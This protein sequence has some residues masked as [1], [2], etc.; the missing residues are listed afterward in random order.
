M[1]ELEHLAQTISEVSYYID[2][3][4]FTTDEEIRG[5]TICDHLELA[6]LEAI[7]LYQNGTYFVDKACSVPVKERSYTRRRTDVE[8][9][10][11]A[12]DVDLAEATGIPDKAA[13]HIVFMNTSN[14]LRDLRHVADALGITLDELFW[15]L[16]KLEERKE[17]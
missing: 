5:H 13:E 3:A 4:T 12:A 17:S 9:L 11:R 16:Y 15:K 10:L 2:G 14:D 6:R 8:S 7:G 1:N